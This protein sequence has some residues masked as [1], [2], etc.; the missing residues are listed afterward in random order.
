M[1][2]VS[3]MIESAKER[4]RPIVMTTC[5]MIAGMTPIALALDPGGAQRQALGVVVIGGLIS[6]LVLTLGLGAGHVHVAWTDEAAPVEADPVMRFTRL[7]VERPTLVTVFLCRSC[8]IAG[9]IAGFNLVKQQLPNYDVPSIQVL[10]TYSGASTTEMR[11]AIV[12]P[13]EDQIAGAPDLSYVETTIEPGQASIVAVFSLTSDE[14][15]DLVQVQGRVQNSLHQLPN[16]LP[17]PQISIYNPSEAVVVSLARV[18]VDALARRAFGNRDQRRRACARTGSGHFIRPGERQRHGLDSGQRQPE[19][20][21][22]IGF[23]VDRR[24][25][26]DREQQRAR[27]GRHRLRAKPRDEPRHPRRR[28]RRAD[29]CKSTARQYHDVRERQ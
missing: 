2:R 16:D 9:T 12:R 6:S 7:F 1:D 26:R 22:V 27:T 13:L 3:A 11:D 5:A 14:N 8:L 4:F 24:H 29:R 20:T 21:P 23:H 18:V 15:T 10:L 25:Q 19:R 17:T 28:A